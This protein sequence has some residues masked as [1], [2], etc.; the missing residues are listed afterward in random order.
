MANN[1]I[2]AF[3]EKEKDLEGLRKIAK[4]YKYLMN[5]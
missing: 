5:F 4:N 3:F 1:E 2:K